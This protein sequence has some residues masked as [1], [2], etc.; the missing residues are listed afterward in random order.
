MTELPL[1]SKDLPGV[2][3]DVGASVDGAIPKAV[4]GRL[5]LYLRELQHLVGRGQATISSGELAEVLSLTGAQ[6]RKD[7]AHFGHFGHP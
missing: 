5:S 3:D 1:E 2:E 7:L 4:A 6:V